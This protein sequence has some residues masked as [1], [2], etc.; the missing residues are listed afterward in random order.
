MDNDAA[1]ISILITLILIVGLIIFIVKER[2]KEN[3]FKQ[4]MFMN[5]YNLS[6]RGKISAGAKVESVENISYEYKDDYKRK[7]LLTENEKRYYNVLAPY[8]EKKNLQILSKIRLADLIEPKTNNTYKENILF[9]K[10]KAKHIDFALC[11]KNDLNPI[12]LIEVDDKSHN[13]PERKER[14]K[15]IDNAL[16]GAG[17]KIIHIQT[18][19]NLETHLDYLT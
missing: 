15:F 18:P 6:E 14:D 10:I 7:K 5:R 17:Y 11:N 8:A 19:E 3:R 13:I 4:L 12:L 1:G 9:S 2:K 16:R